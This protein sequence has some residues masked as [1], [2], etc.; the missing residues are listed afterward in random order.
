MHDD[1]CRFSFQLHLGPGS[2]VKTT[3][4]GNE[5]TTGRQL[6][7]ITEEMQLSDLDDG[8]ADYDETVIK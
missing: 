3:F 7:T 8:D 5:P 1:N 4:M 2:I 6:F